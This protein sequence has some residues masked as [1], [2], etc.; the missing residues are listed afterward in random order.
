MT[1]VL[2]HVLAGY[3]ATYS[4]VYDLFFDNIHE[5]DSEQGIGQY[6]QQDTDMLNP[7]GPAESLEDLAKKSATLVCGTPHKAQSLD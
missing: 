7:K 4:D 5:A 6:P 1:Y 2:H 3:L